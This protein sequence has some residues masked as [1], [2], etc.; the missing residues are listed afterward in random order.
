MIRRVIFNA[1]RHWFGEFNNRRRAN[2]TRLDLETELHRHLNLSRRRAKEQARNLAYGPCADGVSRSGELRV[3][4]RVEK[5]EFE[6]V[7]E[8]FAEARHLNFNTR[9]L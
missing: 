4:E 6:L 2:L 1:D 7:F 8:T 9:W 5:L 3:V